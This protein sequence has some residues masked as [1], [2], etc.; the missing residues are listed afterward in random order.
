MEAA[1][2]FEKESGTAPGVD[3][4]SITDR[5]EIRKAVQNGNIQDAINR[6][7]D[8]NP[9]VRIFCRETAPLKRLGDPRG[10]G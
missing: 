5:M 4:E 6:V 1:R 8:L 9:E 3:L 7:N 2:L 10:L